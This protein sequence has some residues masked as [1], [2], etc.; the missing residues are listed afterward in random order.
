[1]SKFFYATVDSEDA[2][3][4]LITSTLLGEDGAN[5]S[6]YLNGSTSTTTAHGLTVSSFT[7]EEEMKRMGD[8]W[9][10]NNEGRIFFRTN[11]PYM[12]NNTIKVSYIAGEP[13]VPGIICD[14]AT[15]LVA[16][17][18]LRADDQT[19]LIAET[20][21]NIDTKGKYDLLKQ[22]AEELLKISKETVFFIE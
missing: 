14:A 11:F 2:T 18:V 10:I 8:W 15:K 22:E 13:R 19:V 9:S 5:C 6:I 7:D 4:V 3:K 20:G 12:E 16:C 1:M 17:E 21:A